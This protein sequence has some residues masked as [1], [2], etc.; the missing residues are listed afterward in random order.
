M[1]PAPSMVRSLL[2]QYGRSNFSSEADHYFALNSLM[3]SAAKSRVL[4]D[5][6]W[7]EATNDHA[8]FAH[9]QQLYDSYGDLPTVEKNAIVL[10]RVNLEALL[11]RLDSTTMHAGLEA[12]VPYTDHHLVESMFRLPFRYRI[13][14]AQGTELGS[15]SSADLS[16]QGRLRAKRILRTV[17]NRLMPARLANRKKASFPTGVNRWLQ[18]EWAGWLSSYLAKSR[19]AHY[20]LSGSFR[21][22]LIRAP[23]L[24]G[25]WLWPITNLAIWGDQEFFGSTA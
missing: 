25:M 20:F 3:P 12:R 6:I 14:V 9:Y 5:Y 2:K 16:A 7:E 19:F 15:Y 10:H 24:A 17:A 4:A 18:G 1:R 23:Q 8:M 11:S 13:D 21:E 22:E